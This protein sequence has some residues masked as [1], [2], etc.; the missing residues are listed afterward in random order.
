MS[1]DNE[2]GEWIIHDGKGC[3]CRGMV[4][5]AIRR[6]GERIGPY[7]A[8]TIRKGNPEE[9]SAISDSWVHLP[10]PTDIIRYRIRKPK[11]LQILEALLQDLPETVE[12]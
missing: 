5:E 11:G 1:A 7:I 12:A 3:P 2:W 6:N 8:M 4:V 10:K 9:G